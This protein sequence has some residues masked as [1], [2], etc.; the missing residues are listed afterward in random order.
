MAG[1]D[2][3]NIV[4]PTVKSPAAFIVE[5]DKTKHVNFMSNVVDADTMRKVQSAVLHDLANILMNS[6]GPHGSNTCIK[7]L[8]ALNM[9]TKDGHTI[10]SAIQYN[11]I[12]EQAVHDDIVTITENIAKTVGDGTTSAVLMA[13]H[14]FDLIL[15]DLKVHDEF[16]AADF[17]RAMDEV[18]KEL[19]KRIRDSAHEAT[20]QDIYD[21]ALVSSNGDP[22]IAQLLYSVYDTGGMNVFVDVA[23]STA[24]DVSVKIYD[25]M[26]LDSGM[27]DSVFVTDT[28]RNVSVVDNPQVYFF[29][30]PIDTKEMGVLLDA[31]VS[32][33]IMMPLKEKH[34]SAMVPTVIVAP[35]ISRDMSSFMDLLIN[36]QTQSAPGNKLPITFVLNRT[37]TEQIRDIAVMCGAKSIFKYIDSEIY[38]NDVEKGLAPTPQNI[39]EWAGR[40]AS[41][42]AGTTKTKFIDPVKMK[43]E[44]GEYTQAYNSLLSF[45]EA[46]IKK[47]EADGGNVRE[48]GTLKRRLHALKSNLV[49]IHVGGMTAADRDAM[50]HLI[51]DAVKNCRSAAANGVGW[52]ANVSGL[53]AS[54]DLEDETFTHENAVADTPERCIIGDISEVY[55]TLVANLY[56]TNRSMSD[57]IDEVKHTLEEKKPLNLRTNKYDGLVKSSI[58]SDTIILNSVLKIIGIMVTCN[59]FMTPS[60]QHNV[61]MNPKEI[62]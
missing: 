51:E 47:N 13:A 41:V 22:W 34:Y 29:D 31:I 27:M 10:M 1:Y 7:K 58:E 30:D 4:D 54:V 28:E 15:H 23:P 9:Y 45:I 18:G 16:T 35:K 53:L 59:Q 46:E 19:D 40:C 2:K 52:G 50:L 12:I 61:Y 60:A 44:N 55:R 17:I 39:S 38:K 49:E 57:A 24:N 5:G 48:I 14:L 6:F 42:E 3:P 37:Q 36:Y 21:I 56:A 26:T 11:G 25:G 8:N 20:L 32:T 33:N 62:N 43:D